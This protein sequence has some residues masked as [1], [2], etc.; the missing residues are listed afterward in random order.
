MVGTTSLQLT[1]GVA[2]H[3]D[4]V[5]LAGVSEDCEAVVVVRENC[6]DED[7]EEH[8]CSASLPF[9]FILLRL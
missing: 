8:V 5:G 7:V 6:R 3:R 4:N 1:P 9:L 2:V